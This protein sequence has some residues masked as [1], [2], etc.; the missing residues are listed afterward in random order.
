MSTN[1]NAN[2]NANQ[3]ETEDTLVSIRR[4]ATVVKGGRRFG[5]SALV[6]VGDNKGR[7]GY[8]SG[9]SIEVMDA[10]TKATEVAKKS[11]FRVSLKEGR[12]LHHDVVG[13]FGSGKVCLRTAPP[14]TG[15]IA[16]GA[17]RAVFK[18]L[19]IQDIV[20]KSL[21]SSNAYNMVKACFVAFKNINSPKMV[22]EKRGK[23]VSDIVLRRETKVNSKVEKDDKK[24]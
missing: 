6:I 1:S 19:G 13:S 20:A 9:K 3:T 18:H 24:D 14:G 15:I 10:K 11:M 17:L 5:F 21:G 2:S 22:A 23:K 12:T 4:V 7:V 16:G 8:G